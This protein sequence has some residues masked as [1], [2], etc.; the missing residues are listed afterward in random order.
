MHTFYILIFSD[1]PQPPELAACAK[2]LGVRGRVGDVNRDCRVNFVDVRLGR[3]MEDS[4]NEIAYYQCRD[5]KRQAM[6]SPPAF[7]EL[8]PV[9]QDGSD[10][11]GRFIS[12]R[13]FKLTP[14][15]AV[16]AFSVSLGQR[17][18]CGGD[19]LGLVGRL[20]RKLRSKTIYIG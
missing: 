20:E 6:H 5:P 8:L 1:T 17:L 9:L 3:V 14:R 16:V 19:T 13:N 12:K 2:P 11:G 18:C 7:C 10:T 15:G 4:L